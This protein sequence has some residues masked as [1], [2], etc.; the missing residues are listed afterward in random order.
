MCSNFSC[1]VIKAFFYTL[2][3]LMSI[4][5]FLGYMHQNF[6]GAKVLSKYRSW[7]ETLAPCERH[8]SVSLLETS[9]TETKTSQKFIQFLYFI[10]TGNPFLLDG[11]INIGLC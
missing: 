6:I 4:S 8:V 2:C 7:K 11:Y 9:E 1:Y 5:A 10:I 3:K